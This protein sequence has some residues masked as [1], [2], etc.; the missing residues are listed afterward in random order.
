MDTPT[1]GHIKRVHDD[2]D[3]DKGLEIETQKCR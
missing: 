1:F 3:K 2:G